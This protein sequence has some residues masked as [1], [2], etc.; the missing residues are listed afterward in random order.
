M[1]KIFPRWG[2]HPTAVGPGG[3]PVACFGV[4]IAAS[5]S[6]ETWRIASCRK[7]RRW[8]LSAQPVG[9]SGW[10]LRM[11]KGTVSKMFLRF[12]KHN[13]QK[14]KQTPRFTPFLFFLGGH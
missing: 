3:K 13:T 11:E 7:L 12:T 6:Q 14:N 10:R 1:D 4:V 5:S 9:A 2:S 8:K